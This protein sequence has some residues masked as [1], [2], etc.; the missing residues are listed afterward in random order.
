VLEHGRKLLVIEV[1]QTT[2]PAYRDAD[3]LKAFLEDYPDA[4]GGLLL[5]GGTEIRWLGDRIL[6]APWT[7]VTG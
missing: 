4:L 5:N 1:K 6:A 3:G 7:M 2:R